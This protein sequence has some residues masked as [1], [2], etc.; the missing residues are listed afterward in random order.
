MRKRGRAVPQ[1]YVRREGTEWKGVA[2]ERVCVADATTLSKFLSEAALPN[3]FKQFCLL[4]LK[5]PTSVFFPLISFLQFVPLLS[6]RR[7]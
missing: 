7:N 1:E 5:W 2:L 6:G 3:R 4:P